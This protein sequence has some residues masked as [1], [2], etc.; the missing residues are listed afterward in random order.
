M[1]VE[2]LLF[3]MLKHPDIIIRSQTPF[4]A[5]PPLKLL[6]QTFVTP[7]E[8]FFVR[9]HGS[10][11]DIHPAQYRLSIN[12]NVSKPLNLSLDE[13]Q[14]KFPKQ[15]LM[16]TLQC[17]G[18]RRSEFMAQ[19]PI[20]QEVSW[21]AQAISNALWGGVPLR[22]VLLAAGVEADA[23]HVAFSGLDEV[24][25]EG[26]KFNFGG[27]IPIEKAMS[28]EVLLAYEM[29][30]EPLALEHGF[31]LRVVVPGYI[32]ARSVKWLSEITLQSSP[33]SNYFQSH[34]Y[35]LFAPEV[36]ANTVD[37]TKGQTLGELNVTSVICNPVEGETILANPIVVEGYAIA[38]ANRRI[39]RV[40][41]STDG[42]ATWVKT[43]LL[44]FG[45]P[46]AWQFW[47][48]ELE[49][50][51]G[52]CKISVRAWDSNGY[53]QPEDAKEIWNFKGYMNNS[54]HRVGVM[55]SVTPST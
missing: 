7:K 28:P 1:D 44:E 43:E 15:T 37:W 27:S 32:G 6:R 24:E 16:A 52:N 46:W 10:V 9:N 34:A 36:Q 17:A 13:I 19:K 47:Q 35:K 8:L 49:L 33:S 30:G 51:K 55:K 40:E 41:L 53:T 14:Q 18:N 31:P 54:W 11:P 12:G 29:N 45:H 48:S 39:E 2:L 50:P 20:F 23:Q 22:E 26:Q 42:G 3:E 25:K 21:G 4:N 5:E 38:S